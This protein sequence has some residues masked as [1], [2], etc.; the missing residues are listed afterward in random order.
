MNLNDYALRSF[1]GCSTRVSILFLSRTNARCLGFGSKEFFDFWEVFSILVSANATASKGWSSRR[2][3]NIEVSNPFC[4][5]SG[6]CGNTEKDSHVS[7]TLVDAWGR[8][9][10]STWKRCSQDACFKKLDLYLKKS[11][12]VW[13]RPV[14][15]S[16]CLHFR[17]FYDA[18]VYLCMWLFSV[19]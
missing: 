5:C 8:T 2:G 10:S 18:L 4:D 9:E 12:G 11:A 13:A 16:G 7:F 6:T 1:R 15:R 19:V 14:C 17:A 3:S